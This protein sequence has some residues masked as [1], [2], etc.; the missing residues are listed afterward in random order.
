VIAF[1]IEG[2]P[3]SSMAR[4]LGVCPSTIQHRKHRL[5]VKIVEFMGNDILIEIQ[6]RPQ[7]KQNLEATK[8]RLACKYDRLQ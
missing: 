3:C 7:W 4:D 2:R 1:L 6:R 5:A 8:E